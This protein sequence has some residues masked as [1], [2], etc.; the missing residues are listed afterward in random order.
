MSELEAFPD[1][2]HE[3]VSHQRVADVARLLQQCAKMGQAESLAEDG[4]GLDGATVRQ[5]QE[6]DAG[7][8][9]ILNRTREPAV[10]EVPG[11]SEQLL[12]KQRIAGRPLDA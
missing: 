8:H 11:A 2:P 10:R 4:C 9:D 7:E 6:V 1:W 3:D 5:G 12:K